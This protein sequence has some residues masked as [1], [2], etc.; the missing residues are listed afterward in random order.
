[1]TWVVDP[2][3]V[4]DVCGSIRKRPDH[5]EHAEWTESF[6]PGALDSEPSSE[7][8]QDLDDEEG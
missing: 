1:M 4:T 7:Y 3:V 8:R 5:D 2:D 6:E